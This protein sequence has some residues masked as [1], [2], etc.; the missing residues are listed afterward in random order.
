[1]PSI[2][3]QAMGSEFGKLHP[4]IRK[5]FGLTSAERTASI[6]RGT[7]D[8]VWYAKWAILPLYIGTSRHI[9]F[10]AAGS[11]VPF[12]IENYAYTDSFGREAVSWIRTFRFP[13]KVRRF[14]A[15]M[16]FSKQR[17]TIV[18]Y[19]GNRQH[20]AVDLD[21]R[22]T[23]NG[24][25]RIRSGEQRFYEGL[26]HFRFPRGL[27]G[28]ADV[29]EWF[30]EETGDFRIEVNVTNPFLGPVFGYSGSFQAEFVEVNGVLPAG[31]RPLREEGRE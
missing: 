30:D 7:M 15:T 3:E 8:R 10:P 4:Q 6:G 2:Y 23:P 11:R 17:Q 27:S 14:D 31:I 16:I 29:C 13:G 9:L 18:D 19:L 21:V 25:I 12:T 5:R 22:P 20:L 24:G 1:M 28:T 26:L